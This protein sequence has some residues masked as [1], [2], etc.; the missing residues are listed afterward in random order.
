MHR[1]F[2]SLLSVLFAIVSTSLAQQASVF[3]GSW[4]G[5]LNFGGTNLRI[6]FHIKDDGNGGLVTTA[7]SPD[8]SAFGIPCDS[9][10]AGN[11]EV[12]IFMNALQ[13][14]YTG[15]LSGDVT[16]DGIFTQGG[17]GVA[18]QLKKAGV[19][20][21]PAAP[22]RPQ[23]PVGPFP[24]KSEDVEY[25]GGDNSA[26][27]AATISIPEGKGPFPAVLLITGSGPQN[28]DEEVM[29]HKP[30]AVLADYLTRRGLVVLRADDRGIG[31]SKGNYATATSA[32]FANDARAGIDFL[33][34]RPEV[35]RRKI[36]M[37]GHSE[38]GM[39]APM[40][41]SSRKDISFLVLLAGPGVKIKELMA[42]QN[43]AILRTSGVGKAAA[44]AYLAFYKAVIDAMLQ[45]ADTAA[46]NE[47]GK[48]V[49]HHWIS[50]TPD[51][52]VRQL[53]MRD[54]DAQ[55]KVVSALAQQVTTPWFRYF[56]N[57]DPQPHLQKLNAK[58]LALNGDRD[59]QVIS[60]QNLDGIEAS[61]KKSRSKKYEI[62]ELPGLNHLF[63]TCT[64]CTIAEYGELEETFSTTAL[65]YIGRWLDKNVK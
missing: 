24:Y 6:V 10:A 3:T 56:L 32:D 62:K 1:K 2:L 64:R 26:T 11:N 60:R 18:L 45:S 52:L 36:G 54:N 12:S 13:A 51:S 30:F 40:V 58:V 7:D 15:K 35:D 9:T 44:D 42:E 50:N 49:L 4:E 63:Q 55:L 23:A 33:L 39:I 37:I 41:A 29:G 25:K 28:R 65:D 48:K 38:G 8:Q 46:A 14:K 20:D 17:S 19:P 34:T 57:F 59:I 22:I 31:K 16:L 43:A 53:G 27:M 61:L 5:V 21:Q 47:A